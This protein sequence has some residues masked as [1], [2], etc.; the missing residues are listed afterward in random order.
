MRII[1][2]YR[3]SRCTENSLYLIVV[4]TGRASWAG[5]GLRCTVIPFC[6]SSD[7][8]MLVYAAFV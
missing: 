3:S 6:F 7:I 1:F 4:V 5:K 8:V 2:G